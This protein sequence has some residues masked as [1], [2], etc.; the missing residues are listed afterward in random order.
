MCVQDIDDQCVLQITLIH[1][2]CCA[3]HRLASQVFFPPNS[4]HK[5]KL[6]ITNRWEIINNNPH[7]PIIMIRESKTTSDNHIIFITLFFGMC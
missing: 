2:V 7:G 1:A 6:V 5:T 4:T 3:L